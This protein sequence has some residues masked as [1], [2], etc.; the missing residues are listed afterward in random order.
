MGCGN[1]QLG[2]TDTTQPG[3]GHDLGLLGDQPLAQLRQVAV[4]SDQRFGQTWE[5][6]PSLGRLVRGIAQLL[7]QCFTTGCAD[8]GLTL[9][10]RKEQHFGEQRRNLT[11]GPPFVNL[12][13]AQG[14]HGDRDARGEFARRQPQASTPTLHPPAK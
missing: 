11:R 14:M 7:D 12:D 9:G 5:R 1:R 13:L 4:A 2:L 6:G 8:E 10:S 3:N